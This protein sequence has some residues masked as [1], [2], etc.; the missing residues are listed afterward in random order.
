M[1]SVVMDVYKD[2]DKVIIVRHEIYD[3]NEVE[4]VIRAYT[5]IKE[6]FES[7]AEGVNLAVKA[8]EKTVKEQNGQR[9]ARGFLMGKQFD[10]DE[11]HALIS[12]IKART[13]RV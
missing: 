13:R 5:A 8:I 3:E 2:G 7:L 11:A 1:E 4:A 9:R 10:P 6:V 12:E